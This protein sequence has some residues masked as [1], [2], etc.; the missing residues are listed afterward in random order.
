[1]NSGTARNYNNSRRTED[2]G[3]RGN[4]I[5]QA[6]T[7][8][9]LKHSIHQITLEM[10]AEEAGVSVRTVLRKYGS[11]EGLF[12]EATNRDPAGIKAIKDEAKPGDLELAVDVLMREYEKTGDAGIRTLAVESEFPFAA[13]ILAKGR[14][15]HRHWCATVFGP[16]LPPEEHPDHSVLLGVYY[17]ATDIYAWKLLR[18]DLG[19]SVDETAKIF[20]ITLQ[21]ITDKIKASH[22]LPYRDH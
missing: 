13:K 15:Y 7:R 8:L 18:R 2:A 20:L 21:S 14:A 4:E 22:E 17:A 1:M 16:F 6:L 3:K 5:L 9:W 12:E 10:I 19:Y 11:K